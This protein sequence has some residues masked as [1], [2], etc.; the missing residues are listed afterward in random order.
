MDRSI[1]LCVHQQG[2]RTLPPWFNY[3]LWMQ[4]SMPDSWFPCL[5]GRSVALPSPRFCI[6]HIPF[7]ADRPLARCRREHVPQ[8]RLQASH[9]DMRGTR[10]VQDLAHRVT[11]GV[12]NA[13]VVSPR[14]IPVPPSV[15]FRRRFENVFT[16]LAA[17]PSIFAGAFIFSRIVLVRFAVRVVS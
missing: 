7:L 2:A 11:T 10:G 13:R 4:P 16:S 6:S 1:I 3:A 8:E 15:P 9:G 12:P 14:G 5:I 17:N